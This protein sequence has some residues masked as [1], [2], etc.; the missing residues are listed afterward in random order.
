MWTKNFEN[1]RDVQGLLV[2]NTTASSFF[3]RQLLLDRNAFFTWH[4]SFSKEGK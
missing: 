2:K 1:L 4:I 3:M